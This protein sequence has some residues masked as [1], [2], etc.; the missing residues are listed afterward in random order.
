M[1]EHHLKAYSLANS[2]SSIDSFEMYTL[3]LTI[4]VNFMGEPPSN[5]V[6][7]SYTCLPCLTLSSTRITIKLFAHIS[8]LPA[9]HT[10]D[11]G[12]SPEDQSG[13]LCSTQ[14]T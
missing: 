10:T 1:F 14:G 13:M 11:P 4:K 2:D 7:K 5:I 12:A 9:C 6:N 8:P 3:T